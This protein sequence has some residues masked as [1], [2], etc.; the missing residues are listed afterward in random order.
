ML[1]RGTPASEH[2]TRRITPDDA[3]PLASD[4]S[5]PGEIGR[6]PFVS[7]S[8]RNLANARSHAELCAAVE[9]CA[10]EV[11]SP[12]L[13]AAIE[14]CKLPIKV[15]VDH[16]GY[17]KISFGAVARFRLIANAP[18]ARHYY[19][20]LVAALPS[21]PSDA[22]RADTAAGVTAALAAPADFPSEAAP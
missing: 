5:S 4:P 16:C 14:R 12:Y 2:E 15:R 10:P 3:A 22:S 13:M 8:H 7:L 20:R 18:S 9:S 21:A 1:T 19:L 11:A 6:A 17:F